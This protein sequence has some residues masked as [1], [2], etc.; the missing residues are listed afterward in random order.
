MFISSN[1]MT[2]TTIL[3]LIMIILVKR[4]YAID[5]ALEVVYQYVAPLVTRPTLIE[6]VNLFYHI[7][8]KCS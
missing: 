8:S 3:L 1:T 4:E 6:T 7:N 5:F 2:Y